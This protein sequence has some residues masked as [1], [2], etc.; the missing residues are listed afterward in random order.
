MGHLGYLGN[1]ATEIL[2]PILSSIR[3]ISSDTSLGPLL[4]VQGMELS[5]RPEAWASALYLEPRAILSPWRKFGW[6]ASGVLVTS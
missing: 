3:H 5:P 6:Y 4:E 1:L 2:V